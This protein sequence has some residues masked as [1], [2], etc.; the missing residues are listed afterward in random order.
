MVQKTGATA[1]GAAVIRS[2]RGF[3][4]HFFPPDEGFLSEDPIHSATGLNRTIEHA[5]SLAP[6]QY[7]WSYKRFRRRPKGAAK[8]Y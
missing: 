1:I 3:R 5:I 2:D 4:L 6:E 7:N 8:L